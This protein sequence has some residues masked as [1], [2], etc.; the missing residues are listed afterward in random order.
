MMTT[1]STR[2]AGV[3]LMGTALAV[4]LALPASAQ[5]STPDPT[6][7]VDTFIGTGSGGDV[8][9]HVDTFTGTSAPFGM[10]QSSPHTPD[11]PSG[12]GYSYYD[13]T[14]TGFSLTHLSGV[15]C[16]IT[17]DVPI[18]PTVGLPADPSSASQPF[19][20]TTEHASPGRYTVILN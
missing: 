7:L 11:R 15:G 9:G 1:L 3:L 10:L 16:P 2:R 8:V 6:D 20:H 14:I 4:S 12:G 18:L 13:N 5:N 17:G 19:D